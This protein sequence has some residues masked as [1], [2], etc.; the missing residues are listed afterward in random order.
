MLLPLVRNTYTSSTD[1][2]QILTCFAA[3]TLLAIP[4]FCMPTTVPTPA[5]NINYAPAV[6]VVAALMSA[7]WYWVW[8][9]RNY[10]GPP[11]NDN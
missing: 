9:H 7:V 10:A 2:Q 1:R 8:G 4:L 11:V 5:A 6:F 3:W